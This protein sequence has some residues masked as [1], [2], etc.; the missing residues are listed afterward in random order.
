[1]KANIYISKILSLIVVLFI[2]ISL[3]F[4][5]LRLLPGGP[6]DSEKRL[7]PQI[8]EN[9]EKKLNYNKEK[10]IRISVYSFFK[11][12]INIISMFFQAR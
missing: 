4:F 3:T 1:M 9:I 5:L 12:F 10:I 11:F 6:F 8:K 2:I 7:P